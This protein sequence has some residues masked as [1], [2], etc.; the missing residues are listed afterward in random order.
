MKD[1]LIPTKMYYVVHVSLHE[2]D[3]E[4]IVFKMFCV[5]VIENDQKCIML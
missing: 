4:N 3:R 5:Q 2:H 1:K